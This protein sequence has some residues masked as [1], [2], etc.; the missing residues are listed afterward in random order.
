MEICDT[1]QGCVAVGHINK[2]CYICNNETNA[3]SLVPDDLQLRYLLWR[4]HLRQV[5]GMSN[6][7][8]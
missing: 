7:N 8:V 4:D 1:Q 5:E 2:E 6:V 3:G